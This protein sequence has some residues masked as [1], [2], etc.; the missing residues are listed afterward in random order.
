LAHLREPDV[1]QA[2]EARYRL[3]R[4]V[5]P[6]RYDLFVSTDLDGGTFHGTLDATVDVREPVRSIT[7]N[8]IALDLSDGALRREGR[9][10]PV[11]EMRPDEEIERVVLS[12]P[13]DAEPGEWVLHLA[14]SGKLSDKLA[15]YYRST[16]TDDDG[17]TQT[18]AVT[19]FEPTDARRAF[20]CW[21]EP[22]LKAVFSVTLETEKGLLAVSNTP[23]LSREPAG[24]GRV[25]VRFADTMIQSPYLVAYVVGRLELT[26]PL[27]VGGVPTRIAHVPGKGHL[28]RYAL[29]SGA[30]SLAFFADYYG[31]GYPEK[32]VDHV[33]IPDFAQGAMENTGCITYREAYLL[34]EPSQATQ[35]E[36][37]AVTETVA[38]ELAHM[39]F[40]DLVTMRWW[41][42][43]WLNEAFAT[44]MA[45]LATDAE[46]PDWRI[47]TAFARDRTIALDVDSL[48]STR[49]I[50]Y[51]VHSPD[52]AAGMFDTLTYTKG[53]A[54]LRMIQTYL[55]EERFRDGIHRY[56]SDHEYANTETH[57]LWD[58]LEAQTGEPVR[59]IM[60]GWIFQGGYPILTVSAEDGQIRF[61]QR[62]FLQSGAEDRTVWDVPLLVRQTDGS[63]SN[64]D[65]VLIEP[66]GTM[67]PMRSAEATVVANAAGSSFLRVLYDQRLRERLLMGLGSLSAVERHQVVD[68]EWAAVVAGM[69]GAGSFL[70]L[71]RSF[72]SEDD[73]YVWQAILGGLG[74]LDRF[75]EGTARERFQSEVR[76]LVGPALSR[77]GMDPA[78]DEEDLTRALRGQLVQS[79]AVLGNDAGVI[80]G[81][82]ELFSAVRAG[83]DLDPQLAS[84]A[85]S[86]VAATGN[87]ADYEIFLAASKDSPTPQDELRYLMGL[88]AFRDRALL[89]RTVTSTLTEDVR[90]QDGPFLLA[91]S[92][93]NRDNGD[94]AWAFMRDHWDEAT[95]RFADSNIMSMVSGVRFLT[96]PEQQEEAE[97]F[98]KEHP[99]PQAGKMLDQMLERQRIAV[100]LRRRVEPELADRFGSA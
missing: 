26:E 84:A 73:L 15:G 69:S 31:R 86:V 40:G 64:T 96:L 24:D 42:G 25:R 93:M 55:G 58:A 95:A 7:L 30:A 72:A 77:L 68:D 92:T 17:R 2:A 44:F 8:V 50:E 51:P 3:P 16:Y 61:E 6:S 56:L 41:N 94:L 88:T 76:E 38:H 19:H 39:W 14:F 71:V 34:I 78:P 10:L 59:R 53:G 35:Q 52:D 37:V 75:V 82:R 11:T 9:E 43:L 62:R 70:D 79:I 28:T 5:I 87:P 12:L 18:I 80:A 74:W 13:E 27:D 66:A 33:A 91:R 98:F 47:W 32:K 49:S 21:D 60:D 22:D 29:E 83:E 97:A 20:P 46:R 54:I 45:M 1:S 67:L 85:I 99:V 36:Q 90:P 63:G 23:E 65:A 48:E 89:E 100:A 57:D 81:S 4:S